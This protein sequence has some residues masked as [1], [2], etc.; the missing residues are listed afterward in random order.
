MNQ[1]DPAR[2]PTTRTN[3]RPSETSCP[4]VNEPASVQLNKFFEPAAYDAIV[5]ALDRVKSTS[6]VIADRYSRNEAKLPAPVA[7]LFT[8][9]KFRSF[10]KRVTGVDPGMKARL[11]LYGHRDFTLRQDDEKPPGLFVYFD[12][13]DDW[14]EG[15]GGETIVTDEEGELVRVSPSANTLVLIDCRKAYP[16][17]RYVNHRAGERI[18][19]RIVWY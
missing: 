4:G 9:E 12:M 6:S 14:L 11:E 15:T 19:A 1:A 2:M 7:K 8:S 16:F 3:A 10:V 5:D 17:V 18:I 13:T